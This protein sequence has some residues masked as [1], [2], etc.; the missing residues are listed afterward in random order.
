MGEVR[1]RAGPARLEQAKVAT[2]VVFALNGW[3]FA[4]WASRIPSVRDELG[5]DPRSLG[6]L[7]LVGSAGSVLGLPLAGRVAHRFGTARTVLAGA[8][9]VLGALA[10]LGLSVGV[11]HSVPL[12]AGLLFVL[13]FGMGQ[14]DVAMNLEGAAVEQRLGRT[15]MPRYHA[16]F[17][18]GTV[19][20]ALASA[21][22]L[23]W[24][25]LPLLAHFAVT[26][27]VV[28]LL[29]VRGVRTF[30]PRE[31]DPARSVAA[32]SPATGPGPRVP[33]SRS[34]WTEPRTLLIG[35]VVLVAAFTEGTANDW[36]S[37]AFIDGHRL[38]EWAGVLGFATFLGLMTLGRVAGTNLLDRY[39]RLPVLRV[40]LVLAGGGSLLVVFGTP[41]LAFAGAAVWGL[42]V[43]LGFP[44]GMS[45]AADDPARAP[46]RV[47]VVS[48]IGYLAFLAGPPLLGFL[49]DHYGVLRALTVVSVLLIVALIA[50]PALRPL[51]ASEHAESVP[52]PG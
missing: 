36:M 40:L 51:S 37:V 14:W 18:L 6:L 46:A 21:L 9:L 16:A 42:G 31:A 34:A 44:V 48:T 1:E 24:L 2:S 26:G 33:A 30:L 38:P 19:A 5:L 10:F 52:R 12:T 23:A 25:G 8:A 50:L 17:S 49:G 47:S 15:V 35:V 32:D 45:A 27:G 3:S 4:T 39:G 28:M 11:L 29:V 43:S 7:L 41:A 22:L 13:C 20:S